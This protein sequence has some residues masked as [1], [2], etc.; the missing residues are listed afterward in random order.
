MDCSEEIGLLKRALVPLVGDEQL[1]AFDVVGGRVWITQ[2]GRSPSEKELIAAIAT[3]GMRAMPATADGAASETIF[4]AIQRRRTRLTVAA[5]CA[6]VAGVAVDAASGVGLAVALGLIEGEHAAGW[7]A[8]GLYAVTILIAYRYVAP[9]A[10][11]A[12]RRLRP[13]MNL[14]MTVAVIGAIALGQWLEAAAVSFL[15]ALSLTIEGWSAGRAR[16]A[17]GALLQLAPDHVRVVA[18][19]GSEREVAPQDVAIGTH[20]LIR[21]GERIA[22][23]GTIV[24]GASRVDESTIT[25]ESLPVTKGIE[26]AV[27]AG[28]IN[29]DGAL[30]VASTHTAGDTTLARV[31]RSIDEARSKRAPVERWV[32]RFAAVYTPIIFGLAV[33]MA[34]VPPLIAGEGWSVWFYRALVLLVIACPCALVISTPVTI[35][36]ALAA[37]ARSG[38]L[39]KGASHLEALARVQAV[40]LDKTGTVTAGRPRVERVVALRGSEDDV[41]AL[42]ASVEARSEHPLARAI[43]VAAEARGAAPRAVTD[44][45]AV[46]GKGARA[47]VTGEDGSSQVIWV[48]SHAYA[49]ELDLERGDMHERLVDLAR[50]GRT[51]V[52]LGTETEILGMIALAD[53][54]RPESLAA[55]ASLRDVGIAHIAVLTGDNRET[56]ELVGVQCGISDVRAELL[57]QDKVTAIEELLEEHGSVAMVGDGV[58]DAPALARASVGIAMG[59]AGTDSAIETA[60]VALMA[61]DL[62]K[63][64]WVIDHAR[65][66]LRTVRV[67]VALS[68]VVKGAFVVLA[69]AGAASLWAAIAA[70]MGT[71]LVVTL[72]GL[73]LLRRRSVLAP[74]SQPPAPPLAAQPPPGERDSSSSQRS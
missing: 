9:R 58:N 23:D 54:L 60:D 27:F 44:F 25:G 59:A 16:N 10:W 66:A 42:A 37:A 28:T 39:V 3:T 7:P 26:D 8:R 45:A 62:R 5:G 74:L 65:R 51:I 73:A 15:F 18:E 36:S 31:V 40:A 41:L 20:F 63:L 34:V 11:A 64:P 12:L 61:D 4:D 55:L 1:L 22:L 72:N 56:A 30:V 33:L 68:L 67:N 71:S 19:D 52:L 2:S 46:P 35:V 49:H 38:V 13:D 29:G 48:G 24:E 70:D 69:G 6:A 53:A 47:T 21:P 32:D 17:L 57:P 43:V 14:L 50:G